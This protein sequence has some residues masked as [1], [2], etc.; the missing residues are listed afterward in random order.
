[1]VLSLD[2]ALK[3]WTYCDPM[4]QILL[5]GMPLQDVSSHGLPQLPVFFSC[6]LLSLFIL[7]LA[8]FLANQLDKKW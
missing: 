3:D 5:C 4:G 1:M 7:L 8:S 6:P 2:Y